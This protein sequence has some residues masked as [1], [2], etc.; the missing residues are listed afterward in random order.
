MRKII[1]LSFL[2]IMIATVCYAE[3]TP[4]SSFQFILLTEDES[5]FFDTN[6]VR[7][8][9]ENI[10]DVVYHKIFSKKG[11]EK[12]A[13]ST[14]RIFGDQFNDIQYENIQVNLDISDKKTKIINIKCFNSQGKLIHYFN[15][16]GSMWC[17]IASTSIN[18]VK[19]YQS[20]VNYAKEHLNE[21][22]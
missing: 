6:S 9:N 7:Y 19:K 21:I 14:K 5:M 17:P 15:M 16:V 12:E 22:R 18:E 4:K 8:L 3:E 2:F 20:V 11:R 13:E 10:L 1:I